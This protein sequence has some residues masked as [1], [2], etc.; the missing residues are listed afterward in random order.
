MAAVIRIKRSNVSGNPATLRAGELAYSGLPDNGSNGGDRLYIGMGT[1]TAGNAANHFVIGGKFF[2]DRLDHTAGTLT[3]SKAL[4]VDSNKKLDELLVDNLSLNGDTLSATS[5][6]KLQGGNNIIEVAANNYFAGGAYG[7][8]QLFLDSA[9]LYLKQL[10]DGNINLIVGTGGSASSQLTFN[11]DGSLTVPGTIKTLS[12]GDLTLSPNGTGKVSIAGAYKLPRIDGSNGYVLTTDG[13]GNVTWQTSGVPVLSVTTATAGLS[14]L[15]YNGGTFTF[16]P[17]DLSS[18]A[19]Q[20]YVTSQGYITSSALTGYATETYVTTQGYITSSALTG[21]ATE[22]YVTTQG[23]ITSSA[24]SGYATETYVTTQGYITSS[25][26]TGLATETYVTTQGYI[27]SSALSGY[28]TES[29][30]T[31]QGYITG[32]SGSDVTTALGY[33]PLQ[34][35]DLSGYATETYVTTQGYITGISGSDVTT[36]LGYTPLQSSDLSGYATESYVTTQGYITSST[37][38]GYATESYVTGRGYITTSSLSVT[39]LSASTVSS[40]TYFNGEFKFTPPDLGSYATQSYVQTVAQGLHIHKPVNAATTASLASITGGSVTYNNGTS[41][42]GAT[43]TLGV[44][45]TVLDGY[46]LQNGDRILVKNES[47]TANNGIYSWATGGTVL[48]RTL[49]EDEISQFAGGDFFFV[50]SGSINGDTGWVQTENITTFGS[51]SIVFQ[52]FAG[53]GTFQAGTGLDLDGNVFSIS[54]TYAGQSSITT[55]GTITAGTWNADTISESRGGTGIT[56]YNAYDLL[57]GTI[58]GGLT[59]LSMGTAGQFLQVNDAGNGLVY[60]DIDG[61]TY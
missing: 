51:S 21:L 43:L 35:S 39:T 2:T 61:G 12:N 25:A 14:S 9:N 41:G 13:S 54:A 55:L 58:A 45:L 42:V 46:T 3:A 26:L 7:G 16:T 53:A 57:V 20:S 28:A 29:Y 56:T 30:V 23:Y 1:E 15:S 49:Y 24:L 40:L 32:I 33:T 48:T 34:S 44:A 5:T 50:S 38:S 52:Q 37:L 18:Y 27:T 10:R 17:P 8:S 60:A 47:T 59:K 22:T 11:N 4:V 6:L 19:T 36:A 31:T